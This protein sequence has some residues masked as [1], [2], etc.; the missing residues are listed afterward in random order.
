MR[1]IKREEYTYHGRRVILDACELSPGTYEVML[2]TRSTGDG[3]DSATVYSEAEAL[4]A[5]DR[6]RA[7]HRPDQEQ[8]APLTGKYAKLRDDLRAAL[9]AGRAAEEAAPSDGGASNFDSPA[10]RLPRW[11]RSKVEQAAR[12]AGSACFVWDLYGSKRY[13][14]RPYTRAQGIARSLNA[15][16]ATDALRR[17]GYE[18]FSY[19]QMD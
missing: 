2:L 9:A 6:I 19:C 15:E 1:T 12:E 13:V 16:A 14:F 11:S 3:I 8:P 7:A 18:A 17:L 4:A 5:F 10:L